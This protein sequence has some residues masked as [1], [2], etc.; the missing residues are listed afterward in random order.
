MPMTLFKLFSTMYMSWILV[1]QIHTFLWP[2]YL[3]LFNSS[4]FVAPTLKTLSIMTV[5]DHNL[6]RDILPETI[7]SDIKAITYSSSTQSNAG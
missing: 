2:Y 5:L 3:Y 4:L 1:Y 6:D 7:K